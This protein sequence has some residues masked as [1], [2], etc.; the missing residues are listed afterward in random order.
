M[1]TFYNLPICK[2][3]GA[4]FKAKAEVRAL[5]MKTKP[6]V[7]RIFFYLLKKEREKRAKIRK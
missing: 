6:A 3:V 5:A 1:L 7:K 2:V 4:S